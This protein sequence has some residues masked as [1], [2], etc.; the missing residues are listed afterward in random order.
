MTKSIEN[1][2]IYLAA[3][4]DILLILVFYFIRTRIRKDKKILVIF[5]YCLSSLILNFIGEHL[6]RQYLYIY[7]AIF[8]IIEYLIF[9]SF[10]WLFISSS[11]MKKI[12]V[13]LS[14]LFILFVFGY[15]E[16]SGYLRIDSLSIGIETILI[17]IYSFYYMYQEMKETNN[18]LVY[19]KYQFWVISGI[20]IYLAGSFFIYIY[21]NQVKAS[22]MSEFWFLTNV[23]YIIKNLFFGVAIML[24]LR[25]PQKNK[26]QNR[27]PYNLSHG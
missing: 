14:V 25:Q 26:H 19:N 16:Y 1:L 3:I 5:I 9:T 18:S 22:V 17:I 8:T 11:I 27:Y 20:L 6:A 21:A 2:F 4:T 15:L 24:Y 12:I 23:F 7:Y 10:F 13:T